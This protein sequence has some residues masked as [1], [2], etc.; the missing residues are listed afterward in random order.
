M[1]KD[2]ED[3]ASDPSPMRRRP[4]YLLRRAHQIHDA[5]WAARVSQDTT[6]T[7]FAVLSV[8]AHLGRADQTAVAREASLDTSTAG[9]VVY[10]LIERGW[11]RAETSPLDRRR[12]LLSLTPDGEANYLRI[13]RAATEL[14][15]DLVGPLPAPDREALIALLQRL[16]AA[17]ERA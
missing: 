4:G 1:T 9:A 7:Q 2:D 13:A 14:T 12:N 5:L 10:R 16:V 8:V 15:D 17:H 11:L 3:A 6:P